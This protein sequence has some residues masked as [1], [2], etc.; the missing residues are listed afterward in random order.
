M[1]RTGSVRHVHQYY[2]RDNGLWHCS[3]YEECT[4]YVPRNMPEPA[5]RKSLCWRC[6]KPFQLTPEHMKQDKPYC[7]ECID[8][9]DLINQH[10]AKNMPEE[11]KRTGL[12]A[13]GG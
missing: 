8:E 4:H 13:F 7:D 12:E 9:L 2:R 6:E 10:L 11:R 1:S 5:G 3:G